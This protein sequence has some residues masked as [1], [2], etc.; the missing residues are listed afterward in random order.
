MVRALIDAHD[1][2]GIEALR[3]RLR[4]DPHRLKRMRVQWLKNHRGL[5]CALQELPEDLRS[6][7]AAE[8]Q[9]HQLTLAKRFDSQ[10]DG[11][12]KL[13]L[14]T[15]DN[16]FIE[17]VML[18]ARTGR[19]A[20]CVSS[21]VGC[22]VGCD[23][24]AT[25]RLGARRNLT[26]S[27]ILD[28]VVQAND[29]LAAEGRRVRNIVFMGMGEP[30]HNEAEV[31]QALDVL[32]H[33]GSSHHAPAH[34]CVSTVGIP[35]AMVRLAQRFPRVHQ[36]LSLHSARDEV[37]KQ[38][39][40]LAKHHDLRE[41][42]A[43]AAEVTS[44][45]GLPLMIEH[46]LLAGVNDGDEDLEALVDWIGDLPAHVNLIPY[47]PIADAPALRSTPRQRREQFANELK[48]RG[49]RVTLRYSLGSDITA[50]CGQLVR[51]ENRRN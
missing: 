16:L 49:L 51:D 21:Q 26:S 10:L 9:F 5:D 25:G 45:Q 24:C 18:R 15:H 28:Q 40:P 30:L 35:A 17:S 7:F 50:A 36:A 48:A 39:I 22:G 47:N 27:E 23:F 32:L 37:R 6:T 2:S 38:L 42:R 19:T 1:S 44:H 13:L 4:L 8:V 31:H 20:L 29:L 33:P 46:L 12:S 43:A 41:L 14:S 34:V 3:K 11:A